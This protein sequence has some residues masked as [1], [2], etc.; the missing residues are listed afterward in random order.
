MDKNILAMAAVA[1]V[2]VFAIISFVWFR[3][4]ERCELLGT[5]GQG[6]PACGSLRYRMAP[7]Q[8]NEIAL[9]PR[10]VC[11]ECKHV[12]SVPPSRRDGVIAYLIAVIL[13]AAMIFDWV[14]PPKDWPVHFTWKARLAVLAFSGAMIWIGTR[15]MRDK[16]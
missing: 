10:R 11:A 6:C 15:V 16:T 7:G 12:Y 3:Y 8:D 2:S 9:T 14:A 4:R 5:Q 13:I 1:A